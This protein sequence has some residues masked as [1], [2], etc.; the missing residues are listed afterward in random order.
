MKSI[1]S[2]VIGVMALGSTAFAQGKPAVVTPPAKPT[3]EVVLTCPAGT[4]QVG[5]AKSV[6]EASGCMRLGQD[7]SRIFH[8]PYVA[9]WPNGTKQA[10]GQFENSFRTGAWAFFD[11]KG[12]KTGE[13]SFRG[14][15]YDGLRVE[16][17]ANGQKKLEE[18]YVLGKRQGAQLT[19]DLTGKQIAKIDY[20]DDRPVAAK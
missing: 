16:F 8:G 15:H 20:V 9:Y 12:V 6:F 1:T 13:T 7:G 17:H 3:G 4:K 2:A 10:E 5:G 18:T 11:E 14:D 19:F